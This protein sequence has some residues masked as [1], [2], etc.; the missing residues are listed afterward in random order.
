M[1]VFSQDEKSGRK[2]DSIASTGS[3]HTSSSKTDLRQPYQL[4]K[5]PVT[6]V[7]QNSEYES[8]NEATNEK[9]S[10]A[11]WHDSLL[12]RISS[13]LLPDRCATGASSLATV[14]GSFGSH[15]DPFRTRYAAIVFEPLYLTM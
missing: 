7:G 5:A 4:K 2:I 13:L 11:Y 3:L 1:T 8:E 6:A 14:Q 12:S 10:A 15:S 9:V